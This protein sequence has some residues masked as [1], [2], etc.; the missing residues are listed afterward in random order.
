VAAEPEEVTLATGVA[1]VT[2][3][4]L[5]NDGAREVIALVGADR[6]PLAV[7]AW[8]EVGGAWRSLGRLTVPVVDVPE[9][10][11]ASV[12]LDGVGLLTVRDGERH[13]TLLFV[14]PEAL[15][16][17]PRPMAIHVVELRDGRL[18]LRSVSAAFGPTEQVQAIDVDGDGHDELL[19]LQ[20]AGTLERE[21]SLALLQRSGP[22]WRST[23]LAP[24]GV[25]GDVYL[26]AVA[27]T[28]GVPG[29]E[30]FVQGGPQYATWRVA[31]DADG[32]T[33]VDPLIV[34]ATP[35]E[36]T[37]PVDGTWVAGSIGGRALISG[38]GADV[39]VT[40]WQRGSLPRVMRSVTMGPDGL[41]QPPFGIG[42]AENERLVLVGS[43][44]FGHGPTRILAGD[45]ET[46][47]AVVEADPVAEEMWELLSAGQSDEL[48]RLAPALGPIAYGLDGGLPAIWLS[49]SVV[50]VDGT[51]ELRVEPARALLGQTV[52][53]SVGAGD[54][55]L[56]TAGGWY[57][58]GN[59][60]LQPMGLSGDTSLAVVPRTQLIGA[61]SRSMDDGITFERV[62][63][64]EVDD[65]GATR[66]ASGP[67]GFVVRVSGP[68]GSQIVLRTG[69]RVQTMT[70]GDEPRDVTVRAPSDGRRDRVYTATMV[71]V[72]PGGM[73]RVE[74]WDAMEVVDGPELTATAVTVEGELAATVR[75]SVEQTGGEVLVDGRPVPV[76]PDG[77]FEV[78]V[79]APPWPHAVEVLARDIIGTEVRTRVD[80][81]G[82]VDYR[83]WPWAAVVAVLTVGAGLVLFLRIPRADRSAP[84]AASD[85][86]GTL[87]EILGD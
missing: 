13:E 61:A 63:G 43:S 17:E 84:A 87:E 67:D 11:R 42:R 38:G 69:S 51:G 49:G 4:D 1:S 47:E 35:A 64:R 60:F 27:D 25:P 30:I 46:E 66:V 75:G 57:M 39:A 26:S 3:D 16:V 56:A 6:E 72:T 34:D 79:D 62:D 48:W 29:A 85:G 44:G 55:W 54:D 45:L 73:A 18:A 10:I 8:T 19:A 83:G 28:D 86:D 53:G 15:G 52:L 12:H 78:R 71:V 37:W 31:I 82:V 2:I 58:W 21:M 76:A 24:G 77:G 80:V 33:H 36:G 70:L 41:G 40:D 68:A 7:E 65:H 20:P 59:V 32:T 23:P 50:W 9:R 5:D 74:A 81:L 22:D 14:A